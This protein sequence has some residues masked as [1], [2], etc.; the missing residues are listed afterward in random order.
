MLS[1]VKKRISEHGKCESMWHSVSDRFLTAHGYVS[2]PNAPHQ[3]NQQLEVLRMSPPLTSTSMSKK[4]TWMIATKR[5]N[6]GERKP[7]RP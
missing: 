4:S 2:A 3:A 5:F 7:W 1:D 6:C